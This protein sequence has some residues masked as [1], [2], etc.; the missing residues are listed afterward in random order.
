MTDLFVSYKSE[1]RPR[2]APLVAALEADGIGV[3]W[4]AHI[5][6]GTEWRE[7]IGRE[8]AAAR[9]VLV[10]WSNRS[11]GPEG[12][13]VRDEATR[14]LRRGAYMPVCID[15]VEPPLGFGETQALPLI[16]WKGNRSDPRYLAVLAAVQAVL[17]GRER[18]AP[19]VQLPKRGIE[20]R[21]LIGGG[22]AA[23]V[24]AG[25]GGW[26]WTRGT[27]S[28]DNRMAVLPFAN[29]SGDPSQAYLGDGMAEELRTALSR[30]PGFQIVSRLSSET[31]R[32][33][34]AGA[35][36]ARLDVSDILAGSIRRSADVVR[37]TAQLINGRTGVERW[38]ESYDRQNQDVLS[39]QSDIATRVATALRNSLAPAQLAAVVD[40]GTTNV[41]AHDLVLQATEL[42]TNQDGEAVSRKVLGLL[43]AA[44][45]LDPDYAEALAAKA[46]AMA[47][48]A[49]FYT[50]AEKQPAAMNAAIAVARR[51][52][53]LNPDLP[54][55]H[56]VLGF[57]LKNQLRFADALTAYRRAN[58]L[59]ADAGALIGYSFF[60]AEIGHTRDALAQ[61]N[62]AVALDPLNASAISAQGNAYYL[63]G[64]YEAAITA[65]RRMLRAAPERFY[66][67]Y[68]IGLSLMWLGRTDAALAEFQAMPADDKFRNVGEAVLAARRGDR[69][70]SDAELR[71]ALK[72]ADDQAIVIGAVHAQRG[73]RDKAMAIIENALAQRSPDI[74]AIKADPMFAPLR[75]LPRFQQILA[76]L[77]LP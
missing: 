39:V 48:I 77:N 38:S 72:V 47:D 7:T 26:W 76:Q 60:L 20:R 43:D 41:K 49:T 62:R 46:G 73:E 36:A 19:P 45:A 70:T 13:F 4:D 30:I 18:P 6:G 74:P 2:V 8:L 34:D 10:V 67:R 21:L 56:R 75:S 11:T 40:V 42:G 14:A 59:G 22:A 57:L 3:W 44:L 65:L 12:S 51:A 37:V 25:A 16:G 1:D 52:I 58:A 29:L 17:T 28:G 53:A 31:V 69:A 71:E 64:D 63:G 50:V 24:V 35:A 9:C 27:D 33:L 54:R 5:G 23:V 66:A 55:A 15:P 32:D 61:A 68:Y